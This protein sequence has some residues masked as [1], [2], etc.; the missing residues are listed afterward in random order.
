MIK[1]ILSLLLC[2]TI[3]NSVFYVSVFAETGDSEIGDIIFEEDFESG[4]IDENKVQFYNSNLPEGYQ[5]PT[6]RIEDGKLKYQR[7]ENSDGNA[8]LRY[9][10]NDEHTAISGQYC[11]EYDLHKNNNRNVWLRLKNGSY[12]YSRDMYRHNNEFLG[13]QLPYNRTYHFK[14]F[15][16]TIRSVY[17]LWVDGEMLASDAICY[18]PGQKSFDSIM[19]SSEGGMAGGCTVTLD[20][21]KVYKSDYTDQMKVD[22]DTKGITTVS[23]LASSPN[24]LGDNYIT[25]D[26]NLYRETPNGCSVSWESSDHNIIDPET[27]AITRSTEDQ[28]VTIT[29]TVTK[30]DGIAQKSFDFIVLAYTEDYQTVAKDAELVTYQSMTQEDLNEITMSLNFI[31]EGAYGS[32]ITYTSDNP[33]VITESGRVIRPWAGQLDEKVTVTATIKYGVEAI[34][35]KFDF[36]VKAEE[37]LYDP[38]I[39]SDEDFFGVYD[40]S[41]GEWTNKGVFDYSCVNELADMSAIEAAVMDGDYEKAK[42]EFLTYMRERKPYVV[43]EKSRDVLK[44]NA[45]ANDF[46]TKN[47][48]AGEAFIGSEWEIVEAPINVA[49]LSTTAD[50]S[51]DL[52]GFYD[53]SS[54]A[55]IMTKESGEG[56]VLR[57]TINGNIRDFQATD[58]GYIRLGRYAGECYGRE[59]R[60][61]VKL[62]GKDLGDETYRSKIKFNLTSLGT[63]SGV[64][65]AKL[66]FKARATLANGQKKRILIPKSY[67]AIWEEENLVFGSHVYDYRSFTGQPNGIDWVTFSNADVEYMYQ[68]CR[69]PWLTSL[70]YEYE[71][72]GD[73]TYAYSA[74]RQLMDFI[75]DHG[76]QGWF[77]GRENFPGQ[78]PRSLDTTE[79]LAQVLTVIDALVESEYMTPDSCTAIMK[80]VWHMGEASRLG[81]PGDDNW[82]QST[83]MYLYCAGY[84]FPEFSVA[85]GT[86]GNENS[87][88]ETGHNH[89]IHLIEDCYFDDGT[90]IE[91]TMGYSIGAHSGYLG[92][93][94]E[95]K[96]KGYAMSDLALEKLYNGTYYNLLSIAP[97][98]IGYNYGD[99]G[100]TEYGTGRRY[101]ATDEIFDD[102]ELQYIDSHGALGTKPTWTSKQ[103]PLGKYTFMRSDW[104]DKALYMQTQ[105]R[106]YEKNSHGHADRNG[107]IVG[108]YG[109]ILLSD[110]GSFTY[111]A[112]ALR[113]LGRSTK[114]HNTVS[115]NNENQRY[116]DD[117]ERINPDAIEEFGKIHE[118]KTHSSYDFLS[119]STDAT[120]GFDHRRSILFVKPYYWIVSDY[121]D[122]EDESEENEMHQNW[123]MMPN[124]NMAIDDENKVMYSNNLDNL[125]I[126]V[127]SA[128]SDSTALWE[129][130]GYWASPI[131]N[132]TAN[133]YGYFSKVATGDVTFDT[134]L[135]PTNS[136]DSK[137]SIERLSTGTQTQ[138]STAVKLKTVIDG[139]ETNGYYYLSHEDDATQTRNFADYSTNGQMAFVHEDT[140]GNPDM[141]IMHGADFIKKDGTV[142]LESDEEI[143]NISVTFSGSRMDVESSEDI[144]LSDLKI[145][146]AFAVK[147][148]YVNGEKVKFTTEGKYVTYDEIANSDI[149]SSGSSGGSWSVEGG[150]QTN[151]PPADTSDDKT[152][153][154]VPPS[155]PEKLTDISGHWAESYIEALYDEGII[156][157]K[158]NGI[159]APDDSITRSEFIA[160]IVRILDVAPSNIE[161][162]FE[163]VSADNWYASVL[164]SALSAGLI[165][166]DTVFRP[167]AVI[168]REEMAAILARSY[169]WKFPPKDI[170]TGELTFTDKADISN[171]AIDSV[172]LASDLGLING[173]TDG[174]FSPKATA[175][176]AQSASVI[177]RFKELMK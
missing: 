64:T 140:E 161:L 177:Y 75:N 144:S 115:I 92:T 54:M 46:V 12:D 60:M 69:F 97:G 15:V 93:Y 49:T 1:R 72:S 151:T 105:V 74:I 86:N 45:T 58:D 32:E 51:F 37:A 127:A 172:R 83:M 89:T 135:V 73:E 68:I 95:M 158:G 87:W 55:E 70:V 142:I 116:N 62:Q 134:A 176:R 159:F 79:R 11:I 106:G 78:Y 99:T 50:T 133:P 35:K 160:L 154:T 20:N 23:L 21:I 91:P 41:S 44:A 138:V 110:A 170:G 114:M 38:M 42:E 80:H 63:L 26:L 112:S 101:P 117:S 7:H 98:G 145:Y 167:D 94:G 14:Y 146:S 61:Y 171:W 90:Y 19:I 24:I 100:F 141:M 152:A 143:S 10:F 123:H 30:G 122:A 36:K 9:Y 129:E 81:N 157:G 43:R 125:N 6:I 162:P 39:M 111:T 147:S 65:S 77:D 124:A 118:W 96:N 18:N 28:T 148:V 88:I 150:S 59:D 34:S 164:K 120:E 29:A 84:A 103:F 102:P 163:D 174:T 5:L 175:T 155:E 67:S 173:M 131:G 166:S 108:A 3:L 85:G 16:D 17:Y 153:D 48:L 169:N 53:E 121:I 31:P 119:Q 25:T 4:I 136:V 52:I 8:L 128:D 82:A 113:E 33:E 47:A 126:V 40:K 22:I 57:L 71:Y 13:A 132:V 56:P 168:S 137:I 156:N 107:V 66:M 27:G 109:K 76:D 149:S 165:S 2:C 139:S 130:E 104:T